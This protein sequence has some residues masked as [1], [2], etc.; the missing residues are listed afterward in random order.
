MIPAL[1]TLEQGGELVRPTRILPVA[2]WPHEHKSLAFGPWDF[3]SGT[4]EPDMSRG[5]YNYAWVA[6]VLSNGEAYA[7]KKVYNH[8]WDGTE[9]PLLTLTDPLEKISLEFSPNGHVILGFLRQAGT[10]GVWWRNPSTGLPALLELDGDGDVQDILL[11]VENKDDPENTDIFLWYFKGGELL[12][13][14]FSEDF[15]VVHG[16][17]DS[18][19]TDPVLLQAGIN[20]R[21]GYQVDYRGEAV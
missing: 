9:R 18:G 13:R 7:Q 4:S 8:L 15:A 17:Y 14:A 19:L 11:G 1:D 5:N 21:Y 12:M 16:P 10:M 6:Y 3:V 2:D 20:H